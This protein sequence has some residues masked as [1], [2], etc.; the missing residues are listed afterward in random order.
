ARIGSVLRDRWRLDE[1][2]GV[3]GMAAVYAATHRNKKRVAIKVLHECFAADADIR[4]RF[5]REGYVANSIGH[6]GVV[7]VDDDDDEGGCPYLVMALLEGET[8]EQRRRRPETPDNQRALE[9][10]PL[11][12]PRKLPAAEV[13]RFAAELLRILVAAHERGVVH[14]DLKPE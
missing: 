8:L 13:L 3:G 4:K 5:L 9:R 10:D 7:T 14:R 6:P 12:S 11:R 1:L 2:L